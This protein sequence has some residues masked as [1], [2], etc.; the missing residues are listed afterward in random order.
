MRADLRRA[1]RPGGRLVIIDI[2]P[3]KH[4]RKLEGVPERGGHGISP[5]SL[6]RDLT[7]AGFEL[8]ARHEDWDGDEDR[9]CLVFRR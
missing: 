8:V 4:W 3:Q 7:G 9:Y 2:T 6:I 1:L 5:E